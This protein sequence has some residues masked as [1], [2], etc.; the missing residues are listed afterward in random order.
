MR[1]KTVF[2]LGFA[3]AAVAAMVLGLVAGRAMDPNRAAEREA[4]RLTA[5]QTNLQQATV[6]PSDRRPEVPA[7]ELRDHRGHT[8]DQRLLDGRWS[9]V[10]FG[11]TF[12]P[13]VCPLSMQAVQSAM[14]HL[15]GAEAAA[16]LQVVF[17]SV[18]PRRD[19]PE[20]LN[21]Y[22]N[23][24]HPD[25]IGL[26]G[27]QEHPEAAIEALTDALNIAHVKQPNPNEGLSAEALERGEL[28]EHYLVD[29]YAG[30]LLVNPERRVHAVFSAPH[31]P[32]KLAA[33][34]QRVIANARVRPNRP[35]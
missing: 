2:Y 15:D 31:E 20:R 29:H 27:P 30:F 1:N 24:Y 5:L 35:V 26:T 23:Y 9:L 11:Y 34:L 28:G 7:F 17:V 19:T 16:A 10:F 3:A 4:Q 18:D 33:D 8:V 6:L 25:F 14:T 12:C 22:V 13:D 21:S 32:A